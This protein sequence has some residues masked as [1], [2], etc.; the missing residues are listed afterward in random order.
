MYTILIVDDE[1]NYLIVLQDLLE[2]EGFE[3]FTAN[4]GQ[5]ALHICRDT[6]LDLVL[7]DMQMPGMGG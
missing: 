2:D 4:N 6:D 1:P 3:V 7:T 5:E